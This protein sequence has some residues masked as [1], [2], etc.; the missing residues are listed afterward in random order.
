[1][2]GESPMT[3]LSFTPSS[4]AA[5][6]AESSVSAEPFCE[7]LACRRLACPLGAIVHLHQAALHV[8]GAQPAQGFW[9]PGTR[10]VVDG[11]QAGYIRVAAEDQVGQGPAREVGCCDPLPR[12]AT[13]GGH[14]PGWVVGHGWHPVAGYGQRPSPGV[15]EPRAFEGR[16]PVPRRVA[17]HLV[18]R[19]VPV[20]LV[21]YPRA[22][23]VW[24]PPAPEQ[25]ASVFGA[26]E[27]VDR[28]AVGRHALAPLPADAGPPLLGERLGKDNEG[29]DRE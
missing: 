2:P 3:F 4:P 1:M 23:V 9:L 22:V 20:V 13:R 14:A 15:G 27:V 6:L 7:G 19:L 29:V 5:S 26:R 28:I 25:Y 11:G 16:E 24:R 8:P 10:L 12:V 18:R 17:Q 21:A